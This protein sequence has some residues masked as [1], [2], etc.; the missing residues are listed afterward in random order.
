MNID[1]GANSGVLALFAD[2]ISVH[3]IP[4]PSSSNSP[5]PLPSALLPSD[6]SS[7]V[8]EPSNSP[9]V[10]SQSPV[11]FPSSSP[12]PQSPAPSTPVSTTSSSA[13]SQSSS[14]PPSIAPSTVPSPPPPSTASSP[15]ATPPLVVSPSARPPPSQ[16]AQPTPENQMRLPVSFSFVG[17]EWQALTDISVGKG[18]MNYGVGVGWSDAVI[19]GYG[20]AYDGAALCTVNN[21]YVKSNNFAI[22]TGDGNYVVG[23]VTIKDFQVTYNTR[24]ARDRPENS[25]TFLSM[26]YTGNSPTVAEVWCGSDSGADK[27]FAVMESSSGDSSFT[28]EDSWVYTGG[29]SEKPFTFFSIGDSSYLPANV[30]TSPFGRSGFGFKYTIDFN[31][32][33]TRSVL[34]FNEIYSPG[35]KYP[36]FEKFSSLSSLKAK[37]DNLLDSLTA[38]QIS[39][40]VNWEQNPLPSSFPQSFAQNNAAWDNLDEISVSQG[41]LPAGDALGWSDASWNGRTNAFNN[42]ASFCTIDGVYIPTSGAGVSVPEPGHYVV[43]PITMGFYSVVYDVR[44]SPSRPQNSRTFLSISYSGPAEGATAKIYCGSDS[45][46]GNNF[47]IR[48]SSSGDSIL[49]VD[50]NWVLTG[51]STS[52]T[53]DVFYSFG[54]EFSQASS[55][56]TSPFGSPGI[57]FEFSVKF[58]TFATRSILF[59]TELSDPGSPPPTAIFESLS[60]LMN[61]SDN[62]LKSLSI[63]QIDTIDN[64]QSIIELPQ[65]FNIGTVSWEAIKDISLPSGGVL[66]SGDGFGWSDATIDVTEN[67]FDAV[68][69]CSVNGVLI[70]AGS[71]VGYPE[72]GHFIVGPITIDDFAVLYDIRVHPERPQNSRSFLTVTYTG[73][74]PSATASIYCAS[75]YHGDLTF[76]VVSSSSGDT[77]FTSADSWVFTGNEAYDTRPFSF[78]NFGDSNFLPSEVTRNPFGGDGI[79]FKHD[80]IV[81]AG[82][83]RSIMFFNEVYSN[84]R[85]LVD[86][87]KFS[88]LIALQSEPDNL[89]DSLTKTQIESIANWKPLSPPHP[90]PQSYSLLDA[91]WDNFGPVSV[92]PGDLPPGVGLGWLD[93]SLGG[94]TNAFNGASICTIDGA[95]I[96][97]MPGPSAKITVDDGS[98]SGHYIY[99][100]TQVGNFDVVYDV[101]VSSD[102]PQTS[103][104]LLSLTYNG[105]PVEATATVYCGSE[106]GAADNFS[107]LESSSSGDTTLSTEDIWVYTGDTS[108]ATPNILY[109]FGDE[110]SQ[111]VSATTNPFGGNG[112][113]FSHFIDNFA[114]FE[115]K[116]ILFF[117]EMYNTGET[118]EKNLFSSLEVLSSSTTLLDTLSNSLLRTVTNWQPI[119]ESVTLPESVESSSYTWQRIRDIDVDDGDING[120]SGFGWGDASIADDLDAFDGSGIC[121]ING[122]H[123][124]SGNLAYLLGEGHYE[125]GPIQVGDYSVMYD[126][127][128]PKNRPQTVRSFLSLTYTGSVPGTTCEIYCGSDTGGDSEFSV[129]RTSSGDAVVSTNDNWAFVGNSTRA[130]FSFYSFGD[131]SHLPTDVTISPFGT[132]GVGFQHQILFQP[133]ET[134]SI[135][136]FTEIYSPGTLSPDDSKFQS[137]ST[138][139]QGI[140]NLLV[141]L[142]QS[143]LDTIANWNSL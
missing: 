42:G 93:A 124:T 48:Q 130:P 66:P 32:G 20:D 142:P 40:I 67:G 19:N 89:L 95:H 99:G 45:G 106:S 30:S 115:T 21:I 84:G 55:V 123:I 16:S 54:D 143:K 120:G 102:R 14:P 38:Q 76:D 72:P 121:T 52:T 22:Q 36:D 27:S 59:F 15:S 105:P 135:L 37:P 47:S 31:P 61:S 87:E 57:G 5:V 140:D 7:P 39:S 64:W 29:D 100:P 44:V 23:P 107:I 101:F 13:A 62:L 73:A 81:N 2:R 79:G 68:G 134:H 49:S 71:E 129:L 131:S 11:A 141:A 118:A 28:T 6:S 70:S 125:A 86:S 3:G 114:P 8:L 110:F 80:I 139:Q 74:N 60:T 103:R 128:I 12:I 63:S 96:P 108:S 132:H 98:S 51:D 10:P 65:T 77:S 97:V 137:L 53:P 9:N 83:S 116:S 50:D 136:F 17:S 75:D 33:E 91:T 112:V 104:T 24:I 94:K 69:V 4:L 18:D 111:T 43:G 92:G 119:R 117:T 41:D 90:L 109:I 82:E 133:G 58:G 138:L 34:F 25:R 78:F 35:T 126:L 56:T 127:L 1:C 85:S 113:G 122:L 88:S 26:A 46:A